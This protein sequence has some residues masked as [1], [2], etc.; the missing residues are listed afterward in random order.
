MQTISF[1]SYLIR[2]TELFYYYICAV[3]RFALRPLQKSGLYGARA[4]NEIVEPLI[5]CNYITF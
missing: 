2:G 3:S 5:T 1:R 4:K